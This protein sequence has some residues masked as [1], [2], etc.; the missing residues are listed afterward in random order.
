MAQ[1]FH[2]VQQFLRKYWVLPH[3]LS[4]GLKYI[5]VGILAAF[6]VPGLLV[7]NDLSPGNSYLLAGVVSALFAARWRNVFLAMGSGIMVVMILR[8]IQSL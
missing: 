6:I 1:W 4:R 3:Y 8:Y 7:F 2:F 5:P